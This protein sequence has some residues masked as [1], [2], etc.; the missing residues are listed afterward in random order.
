MDMRAC[1]YHRFRCEVSTSK[2]GSQL[3][4]VVFVPRGL[5]VFAPLHLSRMFSLEGLGKP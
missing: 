4:G 2:G 3:M 1:I 5:L